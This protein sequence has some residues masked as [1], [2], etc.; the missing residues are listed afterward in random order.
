MNIY[1]G[2]RHRVPSTPSDYPRR[3]PEAG[4]RLCLSRDRFASG[5]DLGWPCALRGWSGGFR[6]P[7]R[8]TVGGDV[9]HLRLSLARGRAQEGPGEAGTGSSVSAPDSDR[10]NVITFSGGFWL[11]HLL[12][13][14]S[15]NLW[16]DQGRN[17][18][19]RVRLHV[20]TVTRRGSDGDEGTLRGL[21]A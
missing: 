2:G 18:D 12:R 20:L 1:A 13:L 16:L 3:T 19:C 8:S 21:P 10:D 14:G 17:Q 6:S 5:S 9:P 11:K 4:R 15:Y 7:V